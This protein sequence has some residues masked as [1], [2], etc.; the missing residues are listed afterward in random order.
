M[1]INMAIKMAVTAILAAPNYEQPLKLS[2]ALWQLLVTAT[3]LKP[4]SW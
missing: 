2:N 4:E 1:A 3:N